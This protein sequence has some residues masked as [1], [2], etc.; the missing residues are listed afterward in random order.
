MKQRILWAGPLVFFFLMSLWLGCGKE[1]KPH[2][3][4]QFSADLLEQYQGQAVTSKIF[5][6]GNRYRMIQQEEGE[7]LFVVVDQDIEKTRVLV[8]SLK[9][10]LEIGSQDMMSLMN[11][12]F[13]TLKYTVTQASRV[14]QG[15]ETI[16]GY[17]CEKY[18]LSVQGMEAMSYWQSEELNFPLKMVVHGQ[19]GISIE[20]TNIVTG[21]LSD[22]LFQIPTDYTRLVV[23]G[24]EEIE[25]PEWAKELSST[26]LLTVPLEKN[27]RE[28]DIFRFKVEAGKAIKIFCQND[29]EGNM[30]FTAVPFKNGH[31]IKDPSM[32]SMNITE[33]GMSGGFTFE[34]TPYEADEVVVR[35]NLGQ[36]LARAELIVVG[37]G[38][39]VS[40]GEEKRYKLA[41]DKNIETR[42]VNLVEAESEV[43]VT[44]YQDNIELDDS[45]IG[46][47][48]YRRLFINRQYDSRK[49]TFPPQGDEMGVKVIRGQVLVNIRQPD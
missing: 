7:T 15:K 44:Y 26:P 17:E 46:S 43:L 3:D 49:R 12:P 35:V 29:G 41:A 9:Q 31:P 39:T 32:S 28:G 36:V 19:G 47:E 20:L 18:L 13:Q 24:E 34:E 1:K 33:K 4:T 23:P 40:A 22:S 48:N 21:P 27:F 11:D 37:Q 10:Y 8:P 30:S 42:L 25:I 38:V 16:S 45:I 5:V 2:P 6:K 14:S